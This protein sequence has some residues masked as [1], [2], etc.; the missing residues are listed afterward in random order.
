MI[1]KMIQK[2]MMTHHLCRPTLDH[3]RTRS[4]RTRP[5][6]RPRR[7]HASSSAPFAFA[8]AVA[9]AVACAH[10]HPCPHPFDPWG[11]HS[12]TDRLCRCLD[13][14]DRWMMHGIDR[15]DR[16]D[17]WMD[18]WIDHRVIFTGRDSTCMGH[19]RI[20]RARARERES[21]VES[22]LDRVCGRTVCVSLSLYTQTPR[23]PIT[24]AGRRRRLSLSLSPLSLESRLVD[25]PSRLSSPRGTAR[26]RTRRRTTSP[27]CT[28]SP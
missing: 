12:A 5:S 18:G 2:M 13:A 19:A 7:T 9:V 25:V 28:D 4:S 1:R 11:A 21:R 16:S 23:T 27:R 26:S 24:H 15:I 22:L 20:A 10:P 17:G 6:P 8:F 3:R 14:I